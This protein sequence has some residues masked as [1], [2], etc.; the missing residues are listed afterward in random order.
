MRNDRWVIRTSSL[1][2]LYSLLTLLVD[3][4]TVRQVNIEA[5]I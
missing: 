1:H 2:L 4:R 3:V 5:L